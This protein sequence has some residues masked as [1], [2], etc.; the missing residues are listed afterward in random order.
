M[1]ILLKFDKIKEKSH[2]L[3]DLHL[4]KDAFLDSYPVFLVFDKKGELVFSQIGYSSEHKEVLKKNIRAV[5]H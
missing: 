5:L 4:Q 1:I 3:L 2:I